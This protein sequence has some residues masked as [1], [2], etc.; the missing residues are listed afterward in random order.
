[1][2]FEE[3]R[4]SFV[5]HLVRFGNAWAAFFFATEPAFFY[6]YPRKF[7]ALWSVEVQADSLSTSYFLLPTI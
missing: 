4:C 5:G 6:L 2:D 7:N 3:Y 1:M